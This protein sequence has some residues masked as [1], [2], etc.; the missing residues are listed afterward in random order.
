MS[1]TVTADLDE[2]P[3]TDVGAYAYGIVERVGLSPTGVEG[4]ATAVILVRLRDGTPVIAETT[5]RLARRA[6]AQLRYAARDI[7]RRR[8][9]QPAQTIRTR[10]DLL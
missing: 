7:T 9:W 3:W 5:V 2:T 10:G 6:A 8:P 1:L 4:T